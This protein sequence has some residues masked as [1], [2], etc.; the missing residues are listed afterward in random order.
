MMQMVFNL[1]KNVS[2]ILNDLEMYLYLKIR[3]QKFPLKRPS[4]LLSKAV[5][6]LL[7]CG[8]KNCCGVCCEITTAIALHHPK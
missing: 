7:L 2:I 4:N 6:L 8:G 5:C 1:K 3:Y